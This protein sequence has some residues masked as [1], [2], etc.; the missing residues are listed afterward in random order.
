[1]TE[2]LSS[3]STLLNV[4]PTVKRV[5]FPISLLTAMA[6]QDTDGTFSLTEL[7]SSITNE[8]DHCSTT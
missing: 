4:E 7:Q 1:M 8:N 6:Q 5:L 2:Y 3:T